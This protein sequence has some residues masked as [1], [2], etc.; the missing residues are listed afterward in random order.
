MTDAYSLWILSNLVE[1]KAEMHMRFSMYGELVHPELIQKF[2]SQ[3]KWDVV[4]YMGYKEYAMHAPLDSFRIISEAVPARWKDLGADLYC[5][6]E[7]ADYSS[8]PNIR[9]NER[10]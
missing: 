7:I 1:D 6:S 9:A 2:S 4:G 3:L 5:Q 10:V 8:K